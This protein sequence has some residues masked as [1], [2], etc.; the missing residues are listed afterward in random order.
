MP[1]FGEITARKDSKT[2]EKPQTKEDLLSE[3]T[4]S[5]VPAKK[6]ISLFGEPEDTSAGLFGGAT[7]TSPAA[8]ATSKKENATKKTSLFGE[9]TETTVAA[10]PVKSTSGSAKKETETVK[11]KSSSLF[12]TENIFS[13]SPDNNNDEVKEVTDFF[14]FVVICG[15]AHWVG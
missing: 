2:P 6:T 7:T 11:P 8:T 10:A 3:S 9:E 5:Q 14:D 12:D 1:G 15:N 4:K 13:G